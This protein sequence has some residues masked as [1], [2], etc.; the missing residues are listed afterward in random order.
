MWLD[1]GKRGDKKDEQRG[2]GKINRCN[3]NVIYRT[4]KVLKEQILANGKISDIGII[5]PYSVQAELP[6]GDRKLKAR[7]RSIRL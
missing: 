1:T 4:L 2:S 3:A 6:G 7:L 5:T